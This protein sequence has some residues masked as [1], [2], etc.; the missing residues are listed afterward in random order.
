[1]KIEGI[2]IEPGEKYT[3]EALSSAADS[4]EGKP[5]QSKPGFKSD[6][7]VGVV[8]SVEYVDGEGVHFTATINDEE[9]AEK[10]QDDV[11]DMAPAIS[12]DEFEELEFEFLFGTIHPC[13]DVPGIDRKI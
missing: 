1:M 6:D 3:E 12:H 11:V 5:V 4:L 13:E 10:L 2:A 7:V 9:M 8:E